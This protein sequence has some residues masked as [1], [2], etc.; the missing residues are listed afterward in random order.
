MKRLPALASL[1]LIM[2][3]MVTSCAIWQGSAG[4]KPFWKKRF[5][6]SGWDSLAG[7]V[8]PLRDCYD[9]QFYDLELAIQP[10]RKRIIGYCEMTM[11]ANRSFERMQID[12]NRRLK[13]VEVKLDDVP[14]DFVRKKDLIYLKT[15]LIST[16]SQHRI[17]V[18]YEGHPPRTKQAP[19]HG[20]LVWEKDPNG[21]PWVS[22]VCEDRGSSL[23]WP[24]KAHP[25]DEPDSMRIRL[26]V[27]KG[28]QAI[29]NGKYAGFEEVASGRYAAWEWQ[30]ANPI[31]PDNV[32]FYVGDF[33]S[34]SVSIPSGD[35]GFQ[36]ADC[37]VLSG[38]KGIAKIHFQQVSRMFNLLQKRFGP[39]PFAADG[40]KIVQTPYVGMEHQSAIAYGGDF[41]NSG[42]YFTMDAF[43]Y[44]LLHE[45]AHQWWGNSLTACDLAET[46]LHE[47]FATYSEALYLE[48][49]LGKHHYQAYLD[50]LGTGIENRFPI[51]GPKGVNF[52]SPWNSDI[53]GKGA[54]VLHSL[55][56]AI[57][58]DSIFFGILKKWAIGNQRQI[59]CTEDF[60]QLANEVTNKNWQPFFHQYLY[61][62]N[63]PQ[64]E[65][66]EEGT[67]L[68]CRWVNVPEEFEMPVRLIGGNFGIRLQVSTRIAEVAIEEGAELEPDIHFALFSPVRNPLLPLLK[69]LE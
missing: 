63:L 6:F 36:Q 12:L 30:I 56:S 29:S 35:Q 66:H 47:G 37:Y 61:K 17:K 19:W 34:F 31:N 9:A 43:D 5:G 7:G 10:Q 42:H 32:T 8:G 55:R 15:P 24:N 53:Y 11:A 26:I 62:A 40:F 28:L 39:Y 21:T 38:K 25:S 51:I 27:P 68:F 23:W 69:D 22:V 2:A 59:I 44:I 33:D 67:T 57:G 41:T 16:G 64:L 50:Y 54:W 49:Y 52:H 20:G 3:A 65:Y 45:T 46:W 4:L 58:Q 18:A 48:E 14:L 60:I 1:L 13:V